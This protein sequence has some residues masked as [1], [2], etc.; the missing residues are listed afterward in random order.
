M[1][2]ILTTRH[3][4]EFLGRFPADWQDVYFTEQYARIYEDNSHVAECFVY[5]HA[6]DTFLFP[7]LKQSIKFLGG[8]YYDFE[9]PYGYGGPISTSID[10]AFIR[11]AWEAFLGECHTQKIIAGFIRFHPLLAN[12]NGMGSFLS[13]SFDRKTVAMDLT[14]GAERIL[15]KEIHSKHRNVIRK[16]QKHGLR[17]VADEKFENLDVFIRIYKLN[18]K[19][20]AADEF[21][22]FKSSY[23]EAI[24]NNLQGHSFIGLV[25][26]GQEIIAAAIFFYYGIF[27]HYHLAGSL[28]EHRCYYPNNFLIYNAA[29]FLQEKGV[30]RFHLGGGRQ[31]DE[32]DS[33]Y[34]FKRRFSKEEFNFYIGKVIVDQSVYA[35]ACSSW[36]ERFPQ[37]KNQ[38]ENY[39]LKYNY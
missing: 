10:A 12:Q 11:D 19:G 13:V 3:W 31:H 7:Y 21:Y 25:Y 14:L 9:T 23:Y 22:D 16:A 38:Y 5:E 32:E 8:K 18:L 2:A 30:R 24:K 33:L 35:E 34:K 29:L 15:N 37:K 28:K 36:K 17:F 26:K 39:L 4:N 20:L 27:G 6:K 1:N